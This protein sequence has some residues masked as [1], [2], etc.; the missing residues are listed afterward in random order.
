MEAGL[1]DLQVTRGKWVLYPITVKDK[2]QAV[3]AKNTLLGI[4]R[5]SKTSSMY[6]NY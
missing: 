3:M 1:L 2:W 4:A 5:N 6:C